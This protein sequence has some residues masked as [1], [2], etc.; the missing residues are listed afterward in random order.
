M[1]QPVTFFPDGS[2]AISRVSVTGTGNVA[3]LSRVLG[4]QAVINETHTFSARL[5]NDARLGYTRRSPTTSP[6][7]TL[8][9]TASVCAGYPR[10]SH[11]RSAFADALP[12]FTITGFEQQLGSSASVFSQYQ[13]GVW[14]VVDYCSPRPLA[15]TPSSSAQTC[16]GTS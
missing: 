7:A 9:G 11:Q 3:G 12:L 10:H 6:G 16:V 14:E 5:L 13:T 2:G 15:A 1:E 4:Q 8:N